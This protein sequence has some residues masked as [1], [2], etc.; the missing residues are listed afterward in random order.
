MRPF[1]F[2]CLFGFFL[3]AIILAKEPLSYGPPQRPDILTFNHQASFSVAEFPQEWGKLKKGL[4]RFSTMLEFFPRDVH[5]VFLAR[6]M[7]YAYDLAKLIYR[8]DPQILSRIHLLWVSRS[9]LRDPHLKD[10]LRDEGFWE[11]IE[12][13]RVLLL[14][15]GIRGTIP[16]KLKQISPL[17]LRHNILGIQLL[18]ANRRLPSSHLFWDAYDPKVLPQELLQQQ[19]DM[20]IFEAIGHT[21]W[22][23]DHYQ[24][25]TDGRW[26]PICTPDYEIVDAMMQSFMGMGSGPQAQVML[27]PDRDPEM[28]FKLMADL[29]RTFRR[30]SV[31]EEIQR[32]RSVWK[33]LGSLSNPDAR[34]KLIARLGLSRT[35]TRA[36]LRDGENFHTLLADPGGC[37]FLL[38]AKK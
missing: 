5:F 3:S 27:N 23:A 34:Q 35:T 8:D 30:P 16:N 26:V 25:N 29:Q 21:D 13:G 24:Q 18:S 32:W 11:W 28:A 10:Y 7:E 2:L 38:A 9:T 1:L 20:L 36:L 22:R 14:D 12:N 31:Q 19:S 4:L 37:N 17:K 15:T 33:K 6:D